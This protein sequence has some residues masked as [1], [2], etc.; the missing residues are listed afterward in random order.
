MINKGISIDYVLDIETESWD[1]FTLGAIGARD[2]TID[3]FWRDRESSL[4][5]R[6]LSL[7]GQV[8][9]WNGGLFDSLWALQK[10]RERGLRVTCAL[11]GTRVIRLDCG[12]LSIRDGTAIYPTSL[13]KLCEAAGYPMEKET[14]LPCVCGK[15][16]GGYCSIRFPMP[17]EQARS[18]EEYLKK[19]IRGTFA[20]LDCIVEEAARCE[21]ILRGSVGSTS[22]ATAKRLCD[23]PDAEWEWPHYRY[24]RRAYYGGRVEVFK[25]RASRGFARDINSAYPA[26]LT[27]IDLPVG[28]P[29]LVRGERA[30]KGYDRG[31]PGI[32]MAS[33]QVPLDMHVP[34]LPLRTPGERVVF[35]TG[36]LRGIWTILE[37]Q[38]A[39][40]VGCDI[41]VA[42]GMVWSDAERI[43]AP[44]MKHVWANR[45]RAL[46]EENNKQLSAWHKWVA[47]SCTGKFAESPQKERIII[48]P[49]PEE[50]KRCECGSRSKRKCRCSAWRP[51]DMEGEI[52]TAPFWRIP[53][54]GHVHW[55]AYL[56]S[57]TRIQL[58]NQILSDGQGGREAL[59]CDTD[60]V[61]SLS[62]GTVD[63][64]NEL[65]QCKDEGEIHDWLALAPKVYRFSRERKVPCV[66][67]PEVIVKG[68]GLPGLTA[69]GFAA[70][71]RGDPVILE[72]GVKGMRSAA[73]GDSLFARKRLS[74]QNHADGLHFGGRIL[75]KDG[76]THPRTYREIL[77]W[78][79][80][81]K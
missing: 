12:E 44:F 60:S 65:G 53:N 55:A 32:Y 24:A 30:Q 7:S 50:V 22:Y 43:M 27:R 14:G 62:R 68:K 40:S 78:E 45:E 3:L 74:R 9:T 39:E 69:E 33:V 71:E 6:L 11:S 5:D 1:Q 58:H 70:F 29:T 19:D 21:Y 42:R 10:F 38:Q 18:L 76:L 73:R 13:A 35:P 26:A 80:E 17:I 31:R 54:N 8:W 59:Y 15:A 79:Q 47:N 56:T 64:G 63:M 25:P 81:R 28:S 72:R 51:L 77:K 34:P 4:V 23:L 52:W 57:A 75:K 67:L 37:L 48:N 66:E 61:Y 41:R 36:A 46:V 49:L 16:C 20:G 2:G